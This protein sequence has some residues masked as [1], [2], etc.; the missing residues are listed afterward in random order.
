MYEGG[1]GN[2]Y[3][4]VHVF[5]FHLSK[6]WKLKFFTLGEISTYV[7]D[8]E[9]CTQRLKRRLGL[10]AHLESTMVELGCWGIPEVR[11]C[12]IQY[13]H[14]LKREQRPRLSQQQTDKKLCCS[15]ITIIPDTHN[16]RKGENNVQRFR[17]NTKVAAIRSDH[18]LW[19]VC[20][21]VQLM[22]YSVRYQC[23]V[24]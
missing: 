12:G 16:T 14:L 4:V 6:L 11:N 23:G 8:Y 19:S 2:W 3:A 20:G 10:S 17:P 7:T 1:S 9:Y 22:Q 13:L 15:S 24:V 21:A 5:I 18:V